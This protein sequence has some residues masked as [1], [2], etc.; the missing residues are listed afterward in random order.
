M[1]QGLKQMLIT[2]LLIGLFIFA[3]VSFAV[4]FGT[5]NDANQTI[6]DNEAINSTYVDLESDLNTAINTTESQRG[7]F[8]KDIPV[9]GEISVILNSIVGTV[10]VF[11]ELMKG[12]YDL[13][14]GLIAKTL[15]INPIIMG[16]ITAII[17]MTTILLAWRV[18]RS[19]E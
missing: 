12:F 13:T 15:G 3:M 10:R 2:S 5:Q 7:G 14:L 18:Y 16:V 9:I 6:L 11:I 19:G 4:E 8:F 17:L 1:P